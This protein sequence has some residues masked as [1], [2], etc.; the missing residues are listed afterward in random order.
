M[1]SALTDAEKAAVLDALVADDARV[2]AVAEDVARL[3]LAHVDAG[4]VAHAVLEV[5]VGL[6]QEELAAHAGRTRYGYVEPTEAAWA[7]L[8]QAVEPWIEDIVRRARLGLSEAARELALGVLDGLYRCVERTGRDDLLLSWAPDFP[9][10]AAD[11]VM[12]ALDDAGLEL[13]ES[14][15]ARVAPDWA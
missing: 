2:R 12:R 6:S 11:R 7:L 14:E 8:E 15:V 1:L 10:E 9:G 5:L 3:R 13:S 4:S